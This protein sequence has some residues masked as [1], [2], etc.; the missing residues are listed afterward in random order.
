MKGYPK[1]RR[2]QQSIL[3]EFAPPVQNVLTKPLRMVLDFGEQGEVVGIEVINLSIQ[4]RIG[5]HRF[6][7]RATGSN[8]VL[9]CSY[10]AEADVAPGL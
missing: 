1:V 3:L 9:R 5:G 10:D 7:E 4:A 6:I 2:E 8:T